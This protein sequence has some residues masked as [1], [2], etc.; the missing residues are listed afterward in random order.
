[1]ADVVEIWESVPGN[2]FVRL[3]RDQHPYESDV[4]IPQHYVDEKG[5]R[6]TSRVMKDM[7]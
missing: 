5:L 3:I 4:D 6:S 7:S 1:M 2:E